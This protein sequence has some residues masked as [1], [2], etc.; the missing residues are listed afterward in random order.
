MTH[1]F[2]RNI[3]RMCS[4][5]LSLFLIA[6]SARSTIHRVPGDFADIQS[7]IDAANAGD[8]IRV[9]AGTYVGPININKS[10]AVIGSLASGIYFYRFAT[11]Q[12][13]D[14]KRML[15]VK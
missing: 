15:L 4:I 10:L 14:V 6:T 11:P 8:T 7:A 9:Y 5:V 3:L 2:W 1:F 13:T 12:K